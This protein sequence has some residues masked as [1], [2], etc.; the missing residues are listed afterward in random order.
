VFDKVKID[1]DRLVIRSFTQGDAL[2]MHKVLN[3]QKVL[4]YLNYEPMSIETV[5]NN[6]NFLIKSYSKNVHKKI[7]QQS[8]A[9]ILKK[10]EKLIGWTGIG[11]LEY[12]PSQIEIYYTIISDYWNKG[13]ASEAATAVLEF[14][15]CKVQLDDVVAVINPENIASKRV[16]EKIGLNYIGN[17][18]NVPKEHSFYKDFKK[19]S[20]NIEQYKKMKRLI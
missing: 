9:I 4:K 3:D 1:T 16:I 8:M 15:F 11:E 12:D 18:K 17:E 13:Y 5:Q 10:T 19:Y 2:G 20:L 7:V 6:V 14:A